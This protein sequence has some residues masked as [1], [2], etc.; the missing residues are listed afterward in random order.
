MNEIRAIRDI[1]GMT[2]T[3]F[4]KKYEIP[5]RTVENW[6]TEKARPPKYLVNLLRMAVEAEYNEEQ[7]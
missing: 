5:L 6:E 3:A 2:R 4:A 7:A 1:T